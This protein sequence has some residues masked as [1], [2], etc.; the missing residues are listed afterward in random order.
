MCILHQLPFLVVTILTSGP[1]D[2]QLEQLKPSKICGF[3][4]NDKYGHLPA[5][6]NHAAP[7]KRVLSKLA[8]GNEPFP[9]TS[10][11]AKKLISHCNGILQAIDS[12]PRTERWFSPDSEATCAVPQFP[13]KSGVGELKSN[14]VSEEVI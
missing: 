4:P 11:E 1:H 14:R 3:Q 10:E 5:P 9:F 7:Y 2:N 8:P 12:L 13:E 6:P